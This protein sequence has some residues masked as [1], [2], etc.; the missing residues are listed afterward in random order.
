MRSRTV[1]TGIFIGIADV[2]QSGCRST[3]HPVPASS[4]PSLIHRFASRRVVLPIPLLVGSLRSEA[5]R[6]AEPAGPLFPLSRR[7][8][9][10]LACATGAV[11]RPWSRSIYRSR[12]ITCE[13]YVCD[14]V[15]ECVCVRAW[16]S[17]ED[18][19]DCRMAARF[20]FLERR[21]ICLA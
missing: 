20:G 8:D 19:A 3:R 2:T 6:R 21:G 12:G 16:R 11:C 5:L 4:I 1:T 10:H 7:S 14:R 9:R 18:T 17:P 15:S 13:P